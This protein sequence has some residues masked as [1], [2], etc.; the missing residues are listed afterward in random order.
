MSGRKIDREDL[1]KLVDARDALCDFCEAYDEC[2]RCRVTLLIDQA[3]A[4]CDSD[5]E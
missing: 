4:E 2:E 5:D 3:Y 1:A